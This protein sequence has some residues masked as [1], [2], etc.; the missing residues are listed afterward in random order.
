MTQSKLEAERTRINELLSQYRR[1]RDGLAENY[2]VLGERKHKN[3]LSASRMDMEL[4]QG[5]D[6]IWEEYELTYEN[7]Q[8]LRHDIAVGATQQRVAGLKGEIKNLGDI[9][10]SAIE[11]YR[12]VSERYESLSTQY[13]DLEKA[14]ADLYTLIGQLTKTMNR[15]SSLNFRR[16]SRTLRTRSPSCSAADTQS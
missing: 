6:R 16:S 8:A 4:K 12:T 14:K 3:E 15:R 9:N 11:D 10:V 1:E 13:G 7:A 2:R 5:A